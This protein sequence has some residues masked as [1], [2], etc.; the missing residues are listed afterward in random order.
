MWL[1]VGAALALSFLLIFLINLFTPT[2]TV[3]SDTGYVP[4]F[5]QAQALKQT[6][7]TDLFCFAQDLSVLFN[8]QAIWA[9]CSDSYRR[10]VLQMVLNSVI[11][12]TIVIVNGV[13]GVGIKAFVRV[14]RCASKGEEVLHTTFTLYIATLLN[15]VGM[16]V[17]LQS[18]FYG[19]SATK[20]TVSLLNKTDLSAYVS[21]MQVYTDFSRSWYVDVGNKLT[22]LWLVTVFSPHCISLLLLP[23][24]RCWRN[25]R[26]DKA[27]LQLDYN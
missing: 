17:F 8:D 21:T 25:S 19:A 2:T 4:T 14:R 26:R 16:I 3:A 12:I 10:Y 22:S 7:T 1:L 13:L 20:A 5:T 24:L 6:Q 9:F 15:S 11:S 23:L 18:D 27:D